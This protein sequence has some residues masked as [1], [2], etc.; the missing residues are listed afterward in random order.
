MTDGPQFQKIKVSQHGCTAVLALA[1]DKVNALDVQA[2]REITSFVEQCEQDP[3]VSA[4]ILTGDGPVFSAGLNVTEVLDHD[5]SYTEVLLE[6][7]GSALLS[8]FRCSMPTVAAVN[9]SAIAGGCLLACTCD[10]RLIAEGARIGVTELR[11][12]V[13]FPV[14]AVELLKYTCGEHAEQLMLEAR[15]LDADE[16]C[17]RGLVHQSLPPSELQGAAIAAAEQ[18][19]SL[20]SGAYALAKASSRRA[21][22]GTGDEEESRRLDRRVLDH[23]QDAHTRSN[24]ERL[25]KPKD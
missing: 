8:L 2:L 17:R 22:F 18:L 1:S 19:A 12:G 3:A 6:T 13:A 16:A 24:L 14:L 9:G 11:V 10:T 25:L 4:L 5:K 20:D 7:L 15:L 21:V 23:W